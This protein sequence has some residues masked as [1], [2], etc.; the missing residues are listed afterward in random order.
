MQELVSCE[1]SRGAYHFARSCHGSKQGSKK[2]PVAG[3][4]VKMTH[5]EKVVT[6]SK[7]KIS[8]K[9]CSSTKVYS[10]KITYFSNFW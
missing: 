4:K 10:M 5:K 2:H 9:I 7:S 6:N 3:K 1:T 8:T